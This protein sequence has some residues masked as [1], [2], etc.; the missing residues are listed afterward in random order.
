MGMPPMEMEVWWSWREPCILLKMKRTPTD[1]L[2]SHTFIEKYCAAGV[3][4]EFL[5]DLHRFFANVEPPCNKR[6]KSFLMSMKLWTSV[7]VA[8]VSQF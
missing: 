7:G 6:S 5:D 4:V 2:K 8:G 1:V 3:S